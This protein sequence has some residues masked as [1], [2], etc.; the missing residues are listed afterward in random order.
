MLEWHLH[1][2]VLRI[3][4]WFPAAVIAMLSLDTEGITVLCL[5]AS[6]IHEGGHAAAMLLLGDAPA[7]VTLNAFGMCVERRRG[8]TLGYGSLCAVSLAGPL[9][10]AVCAAVLPATAAAVHG[11]LALFHL[12]P[13]LSLDGGEA[14][15]YFLCRYTSEERALRTVYIL[16][17]A[18]AVPL[19]AF[20]AYL[21]AY[22]GNF[23][24]LVVC[25]YLILR[26]FLRKG[27]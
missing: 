1:G 18:I 22:N 20:G 25:F 8:E 14:L 7:R 12:L 10:N 21:F 24:L 3:S 6:L 23:T 5:I 9:V 11:V 17:A 15:Y 16:S 27:H 26:M 13:V 2:T 4:L 19:T